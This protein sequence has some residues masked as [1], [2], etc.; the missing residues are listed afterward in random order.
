MHVEVDACLFNTMPGLEVFKRKWCIGS[1]DLGLPAFAMAV[2]H[3]LWYCV[4]LLY[5][6]CQSVGDTTSLYDIV[7][8]YEYSVLCGRPS[9][10]TVPELYLF[11]F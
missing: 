3:I 10:C 7:A 6:F 4:Q 2:T 1:D 11:I 8:G 5:H 9:Y